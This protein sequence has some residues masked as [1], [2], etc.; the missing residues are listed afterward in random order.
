M[1]KPL[2]E[3]DQLMLFRALPGGDMAPRDAQDLMAYPFFSLA[4]SRRVTPIRFEAGGVTLTVEG[5][6]EHGI[7]T[8]WDADVLIWAASHIVQ[9]RDQGLRT[10]RLMAATPH[11]I[12]TFVQRGTGFK[13]YLM[14][15]PPWIGCSPPR[16][17][18]PSASPKGG[19]CTASHGSTNG[20]NCPV[21]MGV[22]TALS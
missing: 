20:R 11:E 13:D 8:I 14:L 18:R 19:A 10:S 7:A 21:P 22:R 6:P 12:L 1:V 9:A 4:K 5:V 16:W 3:R 17:P 2:S 15:K